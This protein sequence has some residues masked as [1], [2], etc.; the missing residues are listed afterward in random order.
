MTI[1]VTGAAGFIGYHVSCALLARGETV[2]GL[3]NLSPYY[4]IALKKARL[5]HLR[6][7]PAFRFLKADLADRAS[8]ETALRP[9]RAHIG[10]IVHLGAQA[11][12]RH[13]LE[14]PSAYADA[15]LTGHLNMLEFARH[16]GNIAHFVYASS[17][18]VYGN[19]KKIPFAVADPVD[20]P[21]S[22]YAAT[23]RADELMSLSYSHLF[24]LPQT[25]L[26]FFTVYG[27]WGRPDM[28]YYKF[29][30][31]ILSG[32]PIEVFGDGGMKRDFTCINDI[33][34]G[35]LA[36][37]DR[38]PSAQAGLPHRLYNLG[39]DRPETL[40]RLIDLI[41][42]AC[43]R[44]ADRRY[45]QT[46]PGDVAA[47]WADLTESRRDLDYRPETRLE[48]GIPRFVTWYRGYASL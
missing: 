39:N 7:S 8:L 14:N 36:A 10:R 47:T 41:E 12:V 11:G 16:H 27:P 44:K 25:G 33:V 31:N 26:R 23:K 29:T 21:A 22:L 3:D 28:A 17:S 30:A 19:N 38:P 24:G 46:P 37:L 45:I 13:S 40:A 2:I 34:P 42:A 20:L 43:G 9:H 6:E 15:N 48:V 1:L 32:R 4:A 18:S 5:A 35:V